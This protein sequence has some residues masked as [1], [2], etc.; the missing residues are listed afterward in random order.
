[1]PLPDWHAP[2]D[3][4]STAL[5]LDERSAV[6][7]WGA[8]R[9]ARLYFD[10]LLPACF[11]RTLMIDGLKQTPVGWIFTGPRAGVTIEIGGDT[12]TLSHRFYDSS[13]FNE[14]AGGSWPP[15]HPQWAAPPQTV[16]FTGRLRAVTLRVDCKL[17]L[18][19]LLNGEPVHQE[20]WLPDLTRHQVRLGNL[21]GELRGSMLRPAPR[22]VIVRV[23]SEKRFQS[24]LGF[25][26]IAIPT[27]YAMLS[28]DAKRQWWRLI[29]EYN[30]LVQREYPMG[31]QLHPSMDN[32][33]TL[34]DAVPHYYGDNFPNS[35]V[36][37]FEYLRKLRALGG[38]VWFEFWSLPPWIGQNV[39]SYAKA[40][41][42]YC[43]ISQARAGAP[44]EIVGIQ[45]ELAQP[46]EMWHRMTLT[47][48][49]ALDAA[50]FTSV[51][52]HMS[53]DAHLG[54]GAMRALA[55]KENRAAWAA[56]DYGASHQYD[57]Q[58]HLTNPDSYD[59]T[60]DGWNAA[61][62]EKPFLS[63]EIC[64]NDPRFQHDSYRLALGIGQLYHKNLSRLNAVAIAYCWTLLNVTQPSYGATRSLWVPDESHGFVPVASSHQLRVFGAYSRRIQRG[65]IRV[66]AVVDHADVLVTAF[67]AEDGRSTLVALNR[68]LR[69]VRLRIDWPGRTFT[70]RE[71]ADPYH[72]NEATMAHDMMIGAGAIVTFTN[73]P[74]LTA[75]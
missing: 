21:H 74:L 13:A 71:L 6:S 72:Q 45:N 5:N 29:A 69:P 57:Y 46:P 39:E 70:E 56:I 53:D 58:N 1:V 27:A 51:R 3:V 7:P 28:G 41:V 2:G 23:N 12:V 73:V 35:E 25:G 67:E 19:L 8:K 49:R 55:F 66:A 15:L 40:I 61:A 26:G 20:L 10:E 54:S 38:Q 52:I 43:Q 9:Q 22:P 59:A 16:G 32:L 64:V 44:P 63:T 60:I 68:S 31:N 33:D 4:E 36:S 18:T 34:A 42:R 65:M 11:E 17:G 62:G 24:V 75:P 14:I 37:D 30:L 47:L 50:G 48:R